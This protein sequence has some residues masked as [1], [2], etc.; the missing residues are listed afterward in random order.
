MLNFNPR[1]HLKNN[2]VI[3]VGD[4]LGKVTVA[5]MRTPKKENAVPYLFLQIL[6]TEGDFKDRKIDHLLIINH[7]TSSEFAKKNLAELMKHA[8]TLNTLTDPQDLV[9]LKVRIKTK[10]QDAQGNFPPKSVVHYY[11]P[12][13]EEPT[14]TI[15]PEDVIPF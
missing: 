9:G 4:Y 12:L 3:P 11:M 6:I 10:I 13:A 14:V 7:P 5:E 1:E 8:G 15:D 2:K